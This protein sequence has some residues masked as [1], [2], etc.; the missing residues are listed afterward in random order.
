MDGTAIMKVIQIL[1][2]ILGIMTAVL[3]AY[4][5]LGDGQQSSIGSK[6]IIAGLAIVILSN[7]F[8]TWAE[9][10]LKDAEAAAGMSGYVITMMGRF[11]GR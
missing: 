3:G 7:I 9:Q 4:D 1:L 5:M 10:G 6:K 11:L 2:S 8:F